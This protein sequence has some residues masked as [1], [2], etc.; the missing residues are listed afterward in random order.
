MS[1]TKVFVYRRG[2]IIRAV[3]LDC[4]LLEDVAI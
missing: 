2:L 4:V 3:D 1:M